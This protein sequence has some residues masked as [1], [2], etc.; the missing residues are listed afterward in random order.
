MKSILIFFILLANVAVAQKEEADSSSSSPLITKFPYCDGKKWGLVNKK[1]VVIIKP[2]YDSIEYF[3]SRF[4]EMCTSFYMNKKVGIIFWN[5][6]VL[7]DAIYDN[8]LYDGDILGHSAV[9]IKNKKYGFVNL[10]EMDSKTPPCT[11]DYV[12]AEDMTIDKDLIGRYLFKK[13]GKWGIFSQGK[14]IV[15]PTI[16]RIEKVKEKTPERWGYSL[17][18]FYILWKG[19]DSFLFNKESTSLD[20][21]PYTNDSNFQNISSKEVKKDISNAIMSS[22]KYGVQHPPMEPEITFE[23]NLQGK[24][25]VNYLA[26]NYETREV[27]KGSWESDNYKKLLKLNYRQNNLGG[28]YLV[29]QRKDGKFG[30]IDEKNSTIIPFEYDEIKL[31]LGEYVTTRKS[32]KYGMISRKAEVALEAKYKYVQGGNNCIFWVN[33]KGQKGYWSDSHIYFPK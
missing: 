10:L 29:A 30:I 22:H 12:I 27:T 25:I 9:L 18:E 28:F 11:L 23:K 21:F 32:N 7:V 24:F 3:G 2:T 1:N 33:D 26:E 15:E 17:K 6:K 31:T 16:D 19:K 20:T 8:I 13:N 14:I 4:S 5:G